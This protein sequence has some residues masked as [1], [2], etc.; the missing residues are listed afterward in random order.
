VKE[1]LIPY[2][3]RKKIQ[4]MVET[5]RKQAKVEILVPLTEE[6]AKTPAANA[7][8]TP[9]GDTVTEEVAVEEIKDA[10]G[11]TVAAEEVVVETVKDASGKTVAQEVVIEEA[12]KE[13]TAE[14]AKA[15]T[16]K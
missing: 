9:T 6:P 7:D 11:K 10:S 2:L 4:T 1:Q 13:K 14:P 3:Q 12:V 15:E 16:K 8:K 5:L